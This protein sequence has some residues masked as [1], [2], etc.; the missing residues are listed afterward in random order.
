MDPK[1]RANLIAEREA[2]LAAKRL[3]GDLEPHL[4]ALEAKLLK[5]WR[6]DAKTPDVREEAW[7]RVK[8]L[9]MLRAELSRLIEGGDF[10]EKR[11]AKA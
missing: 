4:A 6:E 2:G 11:L 5:A 8:A 7:H 10:A 1:V 3:M 9:D